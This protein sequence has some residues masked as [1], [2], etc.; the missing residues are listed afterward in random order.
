MVCEKCEM[1]GGV[2]GD[3]PA[4]ALYRVT[5]VSPPAEAEANYPEILCEIHASHAVTAFLGWGW[6]VH[7]D[8]L[9]TEQIP[10]PLTASPPC[11]VST[12]LDSGTNNSPTGG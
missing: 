2:E 8:L 3:P 11:Q 7:A 5:V 10:D 6:G 4:C 1:L 9:T 12:L